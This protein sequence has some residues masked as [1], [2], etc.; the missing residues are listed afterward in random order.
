MRK[1]L[2]VLTL[3]ANH[4]FEFMR[5]L[6]YSNFLSLNSDAKLRGKIIF[7]YHSIEKGLTNDPIR[8]RFGKIKVEELLKCLNLWLNNGYSLNDS[9]FLSACSVLNCYIDLHNENK[10][11]ITDII[12][13]K[14][15]KIISRFNGKQVG[16]VLHIK[17]ENYFNQNLASF[18]QFSASRRS[19]RNFNG[20][21]IKN[22]MI[23]KVIK[24]AGNAPSVCNRQGYR[25][26]LINNSHLVCEILKIQSGLNSTSQSVRQLMII[27]V[28]R[29]IFVASQEWY[30]VYIDGGIYLQ[31]ILYSL[32]FHK[33]AAV[34]LNWSKHFILD[35]KIEKLINFPKQEKII[36]II[37]I[38]YPVNNFIIPNSQRKR[39]NE[40]LEIIN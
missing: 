29:S 1:V 28:D 30:Q 31:N 3:A 8:F 24:L 35:K 38:G 12:N 18:D 32:H 25:V 21:F 19:V 10:I 40:T 36:A 16:G 27:S 37:A 2:G 33:I 4:L 6:R 20:E 23:E 5:F 34:A 15:R 13:E 17:G 9:Q 26:K 7:L 11:N 39:V 14:D 22:D